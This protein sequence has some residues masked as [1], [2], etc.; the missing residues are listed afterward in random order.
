LSRTSARSIFALAACL[1]LIAAAPAAAAPTGVDFTVSPAT[2]QSGVAATLTGAATPAPLSEITAWEW[3]LDG[4]AATI[5]RTGQT[6]QYPFPTAGDYQVTLRVTSNELV[7]TNQASQTKTVAVATRTPTAEFIFNPASPAVGENVLFASTSS[8]PDG[9]TLTHTWNFG[10]N[11]FVSGTS[12]PTHKYAT[13]GEK[14]VRLEVNDGKLGVDD[15]THTI[16]VRDP[17]AAKASFTFAPAAPLAGESVTFTSTSTPSAG[18][19]IKSQSWDLDSDGQYDDGT[20]KTATRAFDS[21]GVYRV[22]LRVVQAND[23]P[24]IAEG[25]VRVGAIVATFPGGNPT[26]TGP[27]TP[28]GKQPKGKLALMSPFPVVRLQGDAYADR[29]VVNVLSVLQAPP[30]ALVR[31]RCVGKV[32]GC[33]KVMRRKRSKGKRLRFK[34]F[35]RSIYPGAKLQVFVLAK[36]R[37]GKYTG[38]KIRAGKPPARIDLCVMPGRSKPRSCTR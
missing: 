16:V 22:A 12:T 2:P 36:G 33:P 25:T 38:F 4:N 3:D 37:I 26:P 20:G 1:S 11:S 14:T 18:Q 8:D 23:N 5:E 13:A 15:V 19:T 31:V 34:T 35:E 6:V 21:Q 27:T 30:G 9:D 29:T 32:K 17:S 10:D 24:A 28:P 7:G